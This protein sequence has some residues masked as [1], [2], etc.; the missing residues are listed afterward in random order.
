VWHR[1]GVHP[2]GESPFHT[3]GS[4]YIGICDYA[5]DCLPG[6][7][8]AIAAALPAGEHR[9]FIQQMFV[10][11]G[12][13]DALPLRPITE[14]IAKL[15]GLSWHDSVRQRARR[16][17][18]RDLNIFRRVLFKALSPEKVVEKLRLAALQYFD[19]GETEVLVVE[20]GRSKF[21]YRAVPQPIGVWFVPM[22]Q[23]YASV[24][25]ESAGG[26]D[27]NIA[28]RLIPVGRRDGVGLVDVHFEMAWS[29]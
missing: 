10:A 2:V 4:T 22:L 29:R 9:T 20:Q 17:A 19:F 23:G 7:V 12:W 13:Y 18:N 16:I 28:G 24:L 15:E 26:R 3:R 14:V 1:A 5:K 6:G 8:A 27:P 21:I 11:T 25:I